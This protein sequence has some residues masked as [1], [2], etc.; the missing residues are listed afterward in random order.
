MRIPVFDVEFHTIPTGRDRGEA[1]GKGTLG[2]TF[3]RKHDQLTVD[4]TLYPDVK[5]IQQNDRLVL[6]N[7]RM[8]VVLSVESANPVHSVVKLEL[9]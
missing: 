1:V 6:D 3:D 7:A 5:T 2:E 4:H 8:F 9:A